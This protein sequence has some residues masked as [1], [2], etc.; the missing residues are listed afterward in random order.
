MC[1]Y[2]KYHYAFI[3]FDLNLLAASFGSEVAIG[4]RLDLRWHNLL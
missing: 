2:N 4:R 3:M 1:K